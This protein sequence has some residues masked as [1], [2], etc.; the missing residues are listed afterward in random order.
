MA[1]DVVGVLSRNLPQVSLG[2]DARVG[3]VAYPLFAVLHLIF[4]ATHLENFTTAASVEQTAIL[5]IAVLLPA[6]LLILT[7]RRFSI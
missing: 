7:L 1:R 2:L 4:H 3:L 5:S 6:T